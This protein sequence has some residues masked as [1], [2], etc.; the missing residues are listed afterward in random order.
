MHTIRTFHQAFPHQL[1]YMSSNITTLH[2]EYGQEETDQLSTREDEVEALHQPHVFRLLRSWKHLRH[3]TQKELEEIQEFLLHFLQ[4]GL[5]YQSAGKRSNFKHMNIPV[6]TSI[7]T[8][9]FW[10]KQ[11]G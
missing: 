11:K 6:C 4:E 7:V 2:Q 10:R 3:L 1:V 5:V 8:C 9:L